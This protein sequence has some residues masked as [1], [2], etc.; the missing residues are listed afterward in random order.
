M[1]ETNYKK[2]KHPFDSVATIQL[3]CPI[4]IRIN[5]N[6]R[7]LHQKAHFDRKS[8]TLLVQEFIILSS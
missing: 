5:T 8:L 1:S 6:V 3:K 4:L 7:L 2:R